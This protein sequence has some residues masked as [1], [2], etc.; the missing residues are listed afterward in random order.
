MTV[1]RSAT[2]V[3][4]MCCDHR[5]AGQVSLHHV[6]SLRL[7]LLGLEIKFGLIETWILCVSQELCYVCMQRAQR[8]VPLYQSDE[9]RKAEQ[10]QERVL[11]LHEHQKDLLYFQKEEVP[12]LTQSFTKGL[13]SVGITLYCYKT[14]TWPDIVSTAH[15]RVSM[16]DAVIRCV[17]ITDRW[18]NR[19]SGKTVRR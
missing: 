17:S 18:T 9:R 8:N 3:N 14:N 11:M 13:I 15:L 10:E 12:K 16:T 5:R 4:L 1:K 7:S 19:R 2:D 6:H